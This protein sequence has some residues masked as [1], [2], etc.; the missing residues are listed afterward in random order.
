MTYILMAVIIFLL[1]VFLIG[2]YN[3]KFRFYNDDEGRVG[4]IVIVGGY[5]L[6]WIL[7]VP[8]TLIGLVIAGVVVGSL[9]L[10]KKA[11]G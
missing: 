11:E 3:K 9:K 6:F 8:I 2:K 10:L 5:S 7:T 1:G 4:A